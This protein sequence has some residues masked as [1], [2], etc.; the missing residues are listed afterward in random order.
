MV[1]NS[2]ACKSPSCKISRSSGSSGLP[3]V[4]LSDRGHGGLGLDPEVCEELGAVK[5]GDRVGFV[6]GGGTAESTTG[7]TVVA[8]T[9]NRG[10]T[11]DGPDTTSP[12]WIPELG[13][14]SGN[15]CDA[16]VGGMDS[17]SEDCI[18]SA[19]ESKWTAGIGMVRIGGRAF[20][21]T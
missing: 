5:L 6:G 14:R 2:T 8:S 4:T 11:R 20:S 1:S 10:P 13:R 16:G 19:V 3:V 9:A 15:S 12:A 18:G 21:E 7:S 17:E